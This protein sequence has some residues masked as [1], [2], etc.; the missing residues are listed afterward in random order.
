[1]V[2]RSWSLIDGPSSSESSLVFHQ[3]IQYLV[4]EAVVPMQYSPYTTPVLGG[5]SSLDHVVSHPIQP[6]VEEVVVLMQSSIDPTLLLESDKSKE[7]VSPMQYLTDPSPLSGS[8]AYFNHVL[9]I[10]NS[11]PSDQGGIPLS[12]SMPPPSPRMFSFDWNNLV[13]PHLP[14]FAPFQ[15]MVGINELGIRQT[16]LDEGS[17]ASILSSSPWKTLGSP[18]IVSTTDELLAFDRRPSECLG[19]LPMFPI[20]LGRKNVI[21]D[22]LVVLGPLYLN[23]VLGHDYV[24]VMKVVVSMLFYVMHFPHNGSIVFID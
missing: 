13:E 21:I 8:D 15:I 10:F 17:F 24:Y 18:K 19:I 16:I 14:S 20:N 5:D 9:T 2:Q 23:M 1:M 3:Y 22:M 4:D 6:L 12:S 7:V 11:I